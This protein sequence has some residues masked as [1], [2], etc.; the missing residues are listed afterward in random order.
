MRSNL[1]SRRPSQRKCKSRE[2]SCRL[3]DKEDPP[4]FFYITNTT[5]RSKPTRK[6]VI[7]ANQRCDQENNISQLKQCALVGSAERSGEQLGL[8][9][10]RVAGL[11]LEGL[12][13]A[14]DQAER[15]S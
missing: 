5:K 8:H 12:E 14:D 6:V 1:S 3:F 7:D 13:R 10:D 15:T 4:Y 2:V 11:E 9:G